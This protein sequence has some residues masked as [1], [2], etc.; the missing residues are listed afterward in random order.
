MK[1]RPGCESLY[2]SVHEASIQIERP[3]G[4]SVKE[5]FE[6][7]TSDG[8]PRRSSVRVRVMERERA[9]EQKIKLREG[10]KWEYSD[11]EPSH[12]NES[13]ATQLAIEVFL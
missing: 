1:I 13:L 5:L 7:S 12:F 2:Q 4:A 9:R 10:R 6:L 3:R 8:T 11:G